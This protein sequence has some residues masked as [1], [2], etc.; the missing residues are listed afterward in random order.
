[1]T[2]LYG[3]LHTAVEA[4]P[5][6]K[7]AGT[8]DRLGLEPLRSL[9]DS[10]KHRKPVV[11]TKPI[12]KYRSLSDILLPPGSPASPIL[13][14]TTTS[15]DDDGVLVPHAKSDS[16]LA[17]LNTETNRR[18]SASP[19]VATGVREPADDRGLASDSSSSRNGDR[20]HI[21]FNHRVEQCIAVDSTENNKQY[22]SV[23]TSGSEDEEDDE[24]EE[25]LT[26]GSSPRVPTFGLVSQRTREEKEPHTIAR[27]GPTTLKSVEIWPHPSP[28]VF[29]Q[30]QLPE[31]SGGQPTSYGA[32]TPTYTAQPVDQSV[33]ARAARRAIYDY[34]I[35]TTGATWDEEED[36]ATGFDYFNNG[37]EVGMG[38]E[39]DMA[40]YGSTHLVSGAHNDYSAGASSHL[41]HGPYSPTSPYAL[42]AI[43]RTGSGSSSPAASSSTSSSPAHSRRSSVQDVKTPPVPAPSV[44]GPHAPSSSKDAISPKRSILKNRARQ[45]SDQSSLGEDPPMVGNAR[46]GSGGNSPLMIVTPEGSAPSS[47]STTSPQISPHNS[48]SSL[49]AVMASAGIPSTIHLRETA[50]GIRRVDSNEVV[51]EAR[52]RSTSRGSS[53]SLERSASADRRTG[54]SVSPSS[55]YSPPV[56]MPPPAGARPIG[57]PGSRSR[58]NSSDSLSSLGTGMAGGR[59]LMPDVPEAS[60]ESEAAASL[61]FEEGEGRSRVVIEIT[62]EDVQDE[63][64]AGVDEIPLRLDDDSVS[65]STI[66][67]P[68]RVPS[69]PTSS[70]IVVVGPPLSTPPH[71]SNTG[72]APRYRQPSPGAPTTSTTDDEGHAAETSSLSDSAALDSEDSNVPGSEETSV[73]SYARRSLLRASRAGSG[74]GGSSSE[75]EGSIGRSSIESGRGSHDDSY[76]FGYYDED[77]D[78]GIVSRTLEVAGTVRDLL[79]ALS[80]GIWRRAESTPPSTSSNS[81]SNSKK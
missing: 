62:D 47:P 2:W 10:K 36:Y 20:R 43:A 67:L 26:F 74:L 50:S 5:P 40:Q 29:Y 54:A 53:S 31:I 21:S 3:P 41:P 39:Y 72:G 23:E 17:R 38:D 80:R 70:N 48:A 28:A 37:P 69:T 56:F 46:F 49:A 24:E 32:P 33:Q 15:F 77:S 16:N 35:P 25:V 4:V 18:R 34:K 44:R 58:G 73:P 51:R 11:V 75:R 71:G 65:N 7:I 59:E 52:G 6:P 22:P 55:S 12:L 81:K 42:D 57:I 13:E 79:G 63:G 1:M 30:D 78:G 8:A 19:H 68:P 45:N 9:S 64:I 27:L 61:D 60:S 76:G 66:S 14:A